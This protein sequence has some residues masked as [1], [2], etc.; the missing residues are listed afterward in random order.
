M[1]KDAMLKDTMLNYG[2]WLAVVSLVVF[3]LERLFPWRKDQPV[4]RPLL[5]QDIFWLIFNGYVFGHLLWKV[6]GPL[7]K[8]VDNGL[9]PLFGQL[10][11]SLNVLSGLPLWAQV[12]T[13]LVARDVVEWCVHNLLHRWEPLWRIHR[14]H[15]SITTMDWIGNFRFHWGE[16]IV[17]NTL[18]F[19]PLLALGVSIEAS[20]IA[21]VFATLIGHLNHSNIDLSYGPLRYVFNS[22]RMHL[23]HH[24]A[25]IRLSAGVN[26]GIVFSCWDWIFRTVYF[27]RDR[28]PDRIGF[29]GD[30][31]FPTALWWRFFLPFKDRKAA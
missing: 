10:P 23:W 17:Y 9:T 4:L 29:E 27:P 7:S 14:V 15:H 16:V 22:P 26:Y 28:T 31:A 3:G 5:A 25:R 1:L 8:A 12:V 18:K 11:S 19:L 20:M 24:E 6:S 2:F 21:A 13:I 30:D